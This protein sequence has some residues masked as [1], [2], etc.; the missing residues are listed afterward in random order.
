M[1]FNVGPFGS[2][3]VTK[4]RAVERW[5]GNGGT[6]KQYTSRI[7]PTVQSTSKS[8]HSSYLKADRKVRILI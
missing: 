4:S 3:E 5:F 2:G 8:N 1:S 7:L 6:V